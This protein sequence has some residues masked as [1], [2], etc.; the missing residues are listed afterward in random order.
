MLR[1]LTSLI[2]GAM[3]AYTGMRIVLVGRLRE[4]VLLWYVLTSNK[5]PSFH[6]PRITFRLS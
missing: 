4:G 6:F 2:S 5:E 1:L 3:E